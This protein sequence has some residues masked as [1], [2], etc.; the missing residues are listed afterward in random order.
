MIFVY[1]CK[2][3]YACVSVCINIYICVC[4]SKSFLRSSQFPI[5]A[6]PR[7]GINTHPRRL[8]LSFQQ[9]QHGHSFFYFQR[10]PPST[11]T[12]PNPATGCPSFLMPYQFSAWMCTEKRRKNILL[13]QK[14]YCPRHWC[15]ITSVTTL[16]YWN[17][18]RRLQREC[19]K[20]SGGGLCPLWQ[21]SVL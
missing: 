16:I 21:Y 19:I 17:W 4:A 7:L 3:V 13:V 20:C 18:V 14:N 15:T 8:T 5:T 9:Q 1:M 10:K 11:Q 2:L 6:Q 12:K